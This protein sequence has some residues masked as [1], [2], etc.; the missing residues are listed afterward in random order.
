VTAQALL[1]VEGIHKTFG[2]LQVSRGISL[3]LP[4]GARH[5]LI[6][7][8]GAGKTTFVNIVSGL[9]QPSAGKISIQ[10][11]DVTRASAEKRVRMGLVRTFQISSL[12]THLTVAENVALG[13]SARKRTDWLPWGE[14]RRQT[15]MLDETADILDRTGLLK[16]ATTRLSRLAYGQRRL[17]EIAI[18]LALRPQIL[19]L[20]EPAAGL[21]SADR[22]V[23][24]D[25]LTALPPELAVLI[26]EHDMSLVFRL[27]R[28]ISVLVEGAVLTEG[29]VEEIRN[30]QRVRD[31]YLG[32]SAHG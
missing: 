15:G 26:I 22:E 11:T 24:F 29:S 30:D 16:L 10:G 1:E 4:A 23:L 21:S 13:V 32:S 17:V 5:A 8:N 7:P 3:T 20:D 14:M 12:F 2:A 25:L 6:G 18:A 27:A 28:T 19:V 31:V 9:L